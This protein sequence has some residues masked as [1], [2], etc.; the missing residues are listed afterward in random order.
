MYR[1]LG[2][3]VV[4]RASL[5]FFARRA[6]IPCGYGPSALPSLLDLISIIIWDERYKLTLVYV[7]L[8]IHL[9]FRIYYF[10]STTPINTGT[11]VLFNATHI[12][13]L[14]LTYTFNLLGRIPL[15]RSLHVFLILHYSIVFMCLCAWVSTSEQWHSQT[16][17][18]SKAWRLGML[19]CLEEM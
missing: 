8:W 13:L 6:D 9:D 14:L 4:V 2:I 7:G 17:F 16:Q 18:V 11:T 12:Q 10:K 5:A 15:W 19:E 3:C 1:C